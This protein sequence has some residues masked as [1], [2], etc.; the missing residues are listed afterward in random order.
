VNNAAAANAAAR[1]HEIDQDAATMGRTSATNA[2]D[3]RYFILVP[4]EHRGPRRTGSQDNGH[5]VSPRFS[6]V[7]ITPKGVGKNHV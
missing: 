7:D 4:L 3:H 5:G 2:V 6:P 1:V